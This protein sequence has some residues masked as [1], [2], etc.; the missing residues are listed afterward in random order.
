[1][2]R[3]NYSCEKDKDM[4]MYSFDGLL[5]ILFGRK[6]KDDKRRFKEFWK[7]S[8]SSVNIYP[9]VKDDL[10]GSY[11]ILNDGNYFINLFGYKDSDKSEQQDIHYSFA[12]EICNSF[13]TYLPRYKKNRGYKDKKGN[14]KKPF[15]GS[16]YEV[17]KK[18][19]KNIYGSMFNVTAIDM[20]TEMSIR[21]NNGENINNIFSTKYD[22][23]NMDIEAYSL[24]T[25]ITRLAIAAFSNNPC[26]NYDIA[27]ENGRELFNAKSYVS[28][29][30]KLWAND[31]LYGILYDPTHIER[32]FDRYMGEG[33]YKKVCLDLDKAFELA[34]NGEKIPK[35]LI[36]RS[37]QKLTDFSN[38]R[39]YFKYEN[40]SYSKEIAE[41]IVANY[42]E[43]YN[44]TSEEL[45]KLNPSKKNVLKNELND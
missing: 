14:V 27:Y 10:F 20:I 22:N 11:T 15:M 21:A 32:V 6:P 18:G 33:S 9:Q 41:A 40:K 34:I 31:F 7:S 23:E 4:F 42:K 29:E 37:M 16:I 28:N 3:F 38:T 35:E 30:D 25:S 26:V 43:I 12:H 19:E 8:I 36:V 39:T 1:M 24:F 13:T 17:S 44:Q 5:N 45:K 2:F